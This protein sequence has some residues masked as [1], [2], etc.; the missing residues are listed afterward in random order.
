[1]GPASFAWSGAAQIY[2]G[3]FSGLSQGLGEHGLQA[4]SVSGRAGTPH[5]PSLSTYCIPHSFPRPVSLNPSETGPQAPQVRT[6]RLCN[7]SLPKVT[8]LT[9]LEGEWAAG[10]FPPGLAA[11]QLLHALL[12][13]PPLLSTVGFLLWP[14]RE[15]GQP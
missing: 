13:H 2:P 7:N 12:S 6:L 8:R 9:Q 10:T 14:G 1:M 15:A 11:P 4:D 5:Q 3:P